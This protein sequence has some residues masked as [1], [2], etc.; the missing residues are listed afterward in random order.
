M[1]NKLEFGNESGNEEEEE[2]E[3]EGVFL[4]DYLTVGTEDVYSFRERREIWTVG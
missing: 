4:D 1:Y 2:G 3:G